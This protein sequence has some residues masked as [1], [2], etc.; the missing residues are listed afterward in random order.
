VS[1]GQSHLPRVL[2]APVREGHRRDQGPA[3]KERCGKPE[4]GGLPASPLK[5][6]CPSRDLFEERHG[7][8]GRAES[9][10]RLHRTDVSGGEVRRNTCLAN[11]PEVAEEGGKEVANMI[12]RPAAREKSFDVLESKTLHP[13]GNRFRTRLGNGVFLDFSGKRQERPRL[14]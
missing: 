12:P 8:L 13:F 4:S 10:H 7:R 2:V 3:H 11:I 6:R 1:I 5:P 9:R 14:E